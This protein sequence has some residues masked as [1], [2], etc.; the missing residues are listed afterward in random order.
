MVLNMFT[1][2]NGNWKS[3]HPD[4][5]RTQ[6]KK[7]EIKRIDIITAEDPTITTTKIKLKLM[8]DKARNKVL[9]AEGEK[10]FVDLLIYIL[11]LPLA[12]V[13]NYSAAPSNIT[14]LYDSVKLLEPGHLKP[15]DPL[16]HSKLKL[17][18]VPCLCLTC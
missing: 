8:I 18:L 7:E 6:K 16:D 10:E 3:V 15:A 14:K 11:S 12:A 9:F 4:I 17:D 2:I 5:H 13:A 1:S